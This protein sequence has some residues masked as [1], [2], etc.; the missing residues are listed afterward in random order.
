MELK[1]VARAV[2]VDECGRLREREKEI[3]DSSAQ[4]APPGSSSE[5]LYYVLGQRN[6][7]PGPVPPGWDY[8]LRGMV[9]GERRRV[10]L[11]PALAFDMR[12]MRNEEGRV[13]VSS[14]A[15]VEY[16]VELVSLT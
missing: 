8:T 12:G 14:G 15:T 3:V 13:V 5:T 11:P 2:Q 10:M 9:V 1:Y 16:V 7:S 4:H 6:G